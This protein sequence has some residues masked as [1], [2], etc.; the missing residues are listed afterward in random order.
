MTISPPWQKRDKQPCNFSGTDHH[1]SSHHQSTP[2]LK[3]TQHTHTHTHQLQ[4]SISKHA[5]RPAQASNLYDTQACTTS[6]L[7]DIQHTRHQA[8][9]TSKIKHQTSTILGFYDIKTTR[10]QAFTPPGFCDIETTRHQLSR[11]KQPRPRPQH[12]TKSPS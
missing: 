2:P 4:A 1:I 12:T 7:Y 3:A 6:G 10:H 11:H 8:F 5:R 9:T